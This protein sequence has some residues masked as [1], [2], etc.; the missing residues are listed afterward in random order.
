MVPQMK[1]VTSV[2]LNII[3]AAVLV[4]SLIKL[5]QAIEDTKYLA[6]EKVQL[7]VQAKNLNDDYKKALKENDHLKTEQ[8]KLKSQI[9]SASTDMSR[10]RNMLA[11]HMRACR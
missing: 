10:L 11:F 4:D 7:E 6:D 3:F 2:I 8:N 1:F 9:E 5:K